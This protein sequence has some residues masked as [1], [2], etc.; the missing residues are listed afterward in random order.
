MIA[1]AL[2]LGL[3]L[4]VIAAP[5]AWAFLEGPFPGMTGGFGERTCHHCHFDNPINAPPGRVRLT[6]VPRSYTPGERYVLTVTVTRPH[7][8]AAGFQIAGRFTAGKGAGTPAG[9]LQPI[10]DRTQTVEEAG[11]V[12]LQQTKRGSEPVT[13]RGTWQVEWIAPPKPAGPVIFHVAA[14]AAN[15]DQS[16]LGDF[17]YTTRVRIEGKR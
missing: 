13:G 3:L 10:D 1:R 12:Y 8:S 11:Q 2:A 15:A 6:G 14:N 16:P 17:V 9:T 5:L 4:L 7:L